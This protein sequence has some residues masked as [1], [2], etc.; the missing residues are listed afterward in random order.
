[1][2]TLIPAT[3][4]TERLLLR[5][6]HPEDAVPLDEIYVQPQYRATMPPAGADEQIVMWVRR[7]EEDGLSQWAACDRPSGQ[8][9]GRIG[10]I[11]H[12]DWPLVRDPVE[13]GWVLH[14][15]WWGLGLATE[16]GRAAINVWLGYLPDERLY[17]FTAPDNRRSRAVMERLGLTLRGTAD[18]RGFEHVWYALD[19]GEAATRA[20]RAGRSEGP[21]YDSQS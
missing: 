9:I 13:V 5:T 15:D 16:G 20:V 21:G 19:R 14:H 8:L 12:H 17:S 4:E 11:R 10:L 1:M 3:L 18:W 2:R 7:W 6:W